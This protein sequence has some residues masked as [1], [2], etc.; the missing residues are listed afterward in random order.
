MLK[1]TGPTKADRFDEPWSPLFEDLY[2]LR[3]IEQGASS[4]L[5]PNRPTPPWVWWRRVPDALDVGHD[6][7][8]LVELFSG[9]VEWRLQRAHPRTW[10]LRPVVLDS[11]LENRT[12][13]IR[14]AA[15]SPRWSASR[16]ACRWFRPCP[17]A[18]RCSKST[19]PAIRG[20]HAS[21]SRT[22]LCS[23][24]FFAT[25]CVASPPAGR[26]SEIRRHGQ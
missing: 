26:T 23:H 9:R 12:R 21:P 16:A 24:L 10:I 11:F 8:V 6:F 20:F 17:S 22:W 1:F 25:S 15:R 14:R 13:R 2:A 5:T 18:R 19:K 4:I 7:S 3:L